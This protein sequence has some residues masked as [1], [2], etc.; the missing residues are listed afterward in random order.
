VK[1]FDLDRVGWGECAGLEARLDGGR[2]LDGVA[3]VGE[4]RTQA[5]PDGRLVVDDEDAAHGGAG[6]GEMTGVSRGIAPAD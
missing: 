6:A 4:D 5:P 2:G 1:P 3:L